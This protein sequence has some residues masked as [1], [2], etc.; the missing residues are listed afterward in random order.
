M[1]T[2][3]LALALPLLAACNLQ[4][5]GSTN[6]ETD[7]SLFPLAVNRTWGYKLVNS[8]GAGCKATDNQLRVT[9]TTTLGGKTA[10]QAVL[11][12]TNGQV[13]SFAFS[14][15]QVW[16]WVNS[17]W[18]SYIDKPLETDHYWP[19]PLGTFTW[20]AMPSVNTPAGTFT[21]CWAR[22][23]SNTSSYTTFCR[24][25]GIVSIHND[26][27]QGLTWDATLASKAF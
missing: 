21:D 6:A 26:N 15:D 20:D 27:G 9:G 24:G 16:T 4:N 3:K 10:Y 17:S 8:G 12:C 23:E 19:T 13:Q 22:M 18:V 11:P 25:V 2:W 14:G 5:G 1:K 7:G